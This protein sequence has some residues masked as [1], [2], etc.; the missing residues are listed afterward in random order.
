MLK[1]CF[2]VALVALALAPGVASAD[3]L[4]T[5]YAGMT[6]SKDAS[7]HE[8]GM[9]GASFGWMG[10]GVAGAEVDFGY[11]PNFFEPKDCSDCGTFTGSNNVLDLMV[12]AI[13]G[14]PV[15]GTHGGGIRPYVVG[16]VGLLRQQVPASTEALKIS[17]NDFGFDLGF[18]LMGFVSDHVG[19]RGDVRYLRSFQSND[20]T[21]LGVVPTFSAGDFDFWRW[22][23]GVTLR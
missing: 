3:F 12:N 21:A 10:A 20:E 15:G 9:Y 23:V 22:S 1:R 14:V 5:P 19:F 11:S 4:F 8:H 18:G 2:W 17:S 7:G 6:F 16:G 13:L